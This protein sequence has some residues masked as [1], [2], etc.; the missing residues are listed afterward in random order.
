M[1][2]NLSD[3]EIKELRFVYS[4]ISKAID[5][6]TLNERRSITLK[7]MLE[8]YKEEYGI[9]ER[10]LERS[11]FLYN[12]GDHEP[13]KKY[14][15]Y[16][17]SEAKRKKLYRK[18]RRNGEKNIRKPNQKRVIRFYERN[19]ENMLRLNEDLAKNY[20]DLKVNG[21]LTKMMKKLMGKD[22]TLDDINKKYGYKGL[23]NAMFLFNSG[24]FET[25]P[26]L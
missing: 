4:Q 3:E 1:E 16:L 17:E 20:I 11:L 23:N 21:K 12:V 7:A 13:S 24:Y 2:R 6:P 15:K 14:A 22:F 18:N 5:A 9:S 8:D 25:K 26:S 19:K 10:T